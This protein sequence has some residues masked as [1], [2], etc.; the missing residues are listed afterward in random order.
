MQEVKLAVKPSKK[1][2]RRAS[3]ALVHTSWFDEGGEGKFP[4]RSET[5]LHLL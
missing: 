4:T 1:C 5:R 3:N 2:T